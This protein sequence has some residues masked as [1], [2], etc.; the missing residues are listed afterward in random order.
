MALPPKAP[1]ELPPAAEATR[2]PLTREA[3]EWLV[4]LHSGDD[5]EQDWIDFQDWR[6][7]SAARAQ[8]AERAERL[9]EQLGPALARKP[10]PGKTIPIL[11]ACALALAA[12]AFGTG[13]FAPSGTFFA[14]Y[15]TGVGE[16]RTVTLRDGSQVDLDSDTSFD[17][18]VGHRTITLYAGQIHVSV[19]PD[20]ERAFVV[21]AGEGSVR[22]LGTAF[23]VRRDRG[24]TAVAVTEHAVRVTHAHEGATASVDLGVGDGVSFSRAG[25]GQPHKVDVASLTAWR[26]GELVFDGT[27]LGEVVA[28][29]DR[30]RY[31]KTL[32]LDDDIRR[33]RVTGN[34]EIADTKAFAQSIQLALPVKLIE[35]PGLT[36]IRRDQ[37]RALPLR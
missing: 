37:A 25:L 24:S 27:P 34:F 12:I 9:W 28:E 32:I 14:D 20:P 21:M 6:T 22:A 17:V 1:F 7:A 33:L 8:A 26:R 16:I 19:K 18:D 30:Y 13:I 5:T 23:E 31:G 10:G 15:K 3:L 36:L 2:D 29:M 35:M 4:H 11:V